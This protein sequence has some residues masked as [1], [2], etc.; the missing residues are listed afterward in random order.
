MW[1]RRNVVAAAIGTLP[2]AAKN[3]IGLSRLSAI[4][5][6]IARSPQQAIAFARQYGLRWVELRNVPGTGREYAYLAEDELQAEARLLAD[7]GLRVSFL[8]CSLMKVA[9]PD[10][11]PVRWASD[12]EQRRA[13]RRQ[14]EQL[15]FE[16]RLADLRKALQAAQILGSASLRV[17]TGWRGRDPLAALPRVAEIISEMAEIAAASEIR[18]L[19]ENEAACNVATCAELAQLMKLI[20]SKWVGINWDPLNG[21]RY[22]EAPYPDGYSLLPKHRIGN[23]QIKG[24]SI[25]PGP[26]RLDW[27][28][29]LEALE[30]DGYSGQLGLETHIFGDIQIQASHEAMREILKLVAA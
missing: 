18:L 25:L 6:E 20:P 29:I 2:L 8:N 10:I 26:Q 17:F 24:R 11:E 7:S 9:I 21:T 14:A 19:V 12:S 27:P 16:N 22:G 4:T 23:V 30:R 3:R 5:D 1:T 13:A 28:A 15:R